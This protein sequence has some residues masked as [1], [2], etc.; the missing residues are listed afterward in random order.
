VAALR[1]AG[2]DLTTGEIAAAIEYDF[3]NC[4]MTLRRL[5][6]LGIVL[7]V[8]GTRPQRWRLVAAR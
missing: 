1:A 4:Y 2:R 6:Q 8:P 7:L 3:S 5:E